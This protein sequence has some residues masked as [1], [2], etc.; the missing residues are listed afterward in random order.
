MLDDIKKKN[1][2]NK[3]QKQDFFVE[4]AGY[5][6][7]PQE[8]KA[9]KKGKSPIRSGHPPKAPWQPVVEQKS[10]LE[11]KPSVEKLDVKPVKE[12]KKV[13]EYK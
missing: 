9:E 1:A 10:V 2:L 11:K 3:N 12:E 7:L 6:D 13:L 4:I 5:K 8:S